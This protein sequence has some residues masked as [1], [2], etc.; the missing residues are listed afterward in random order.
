MPYRTNLI[1]AALIALLLLLFFFDFFSFREGLETGGRGMYDYFQPVPA[2]N[3][4]GED[5][6]KNFTEKLKKIPDVGDLDKIMPSLLAY[7]Q[8][9]T[10]QQEANYY[11]SNGTFPISQYVQNYLDNVPTLI[12]LYKMKYND[13]IDV[14]N[15][16]ISTFFPNRMIYRIITNVDTKEKE[17]NKLS[18]QYFT[19]AANPPAASG[20]TGNV[21][22]GNNTDPNKKQGL[23]A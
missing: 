7:Y 10:L 20:S 19:G 13:K 23:F 3:D 21:S 6:K 22:M 8:T 15:S 16:N 1:I 11:I 4:W 2:K 14:T 17:M 18:Y 12:A 5:V 9:E